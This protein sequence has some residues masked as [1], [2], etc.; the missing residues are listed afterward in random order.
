MKITITKGTGFPKEQYVVYADVYPKEGEHVT[1]G[2]LSLGSV[3]SVL[4][5][6]PQK[7][8]EK[9]HVEVRIR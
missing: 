8:G 9:H 1:V 6:Y 4:H 2:D 3:F 7:A 5:H